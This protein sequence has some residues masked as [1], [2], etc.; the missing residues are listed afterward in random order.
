MAQQN[1]L[2]FNIAMHTKGMEQIA[3][4][5]NRVSALEAETKKLASANTTLGK[6]TEAVIQNGKR[7]NNALDAQSK[8]LRNAR[9]GSQMAMMQFQDFF[10]SVS[11]GASPI[12]AFN[13]QIGQLGYSLT[14]MQGGLGK[15]GRILSGP[16]GIALIVATSLLGAFKD[17]IFGTSNKTVDFA[18]TANT[19]FTSI[20]ENITNG[21]QPAIERLGPVISAVSQLWVVMKEIAVATVQGIVMLLNRLIGG[22]VGAINAVV[23]LVSN[24]MNIIKEIGA[25]VVNSFVKV[26]NYVIDGVEN[27]INNTKGVANS[28]L[29]FT[30][31]SFRFAETKF[32]RMTEVT[33]QWAG[34]TVKA[35][36]E[37]S[38]AFMKGFRTDYINLGDLSV[39]YKAKEDKKNG[40]ASKGLTDAQK[41]AKKLAEATARWNKAFPSEGVNNAAEVYKD[42]RIMMIKSAE[43]SNNRISDLDDEM[44]RNSIDRAAQMAKEIG[45]I[46]QAAGE[47]ISNFFQKPYEELQNS[48]RTIGQSVSDA[49]KG[50]LTGA[51]SWK[52]GMKSI[53]SAVI[54]QLWQLYVVQQIVGFV[55]KALGGLGAP[56]PAAASTAAANIITVNP[57][58]IA[59][60]FTPKA[61]GG[62]VGA[63]QPYLVGEKGPELFVP[64]GS[65]TIIPNK[66]M[67]MATSNSGG[68]NISVDARGSSDPAAV[69]A[70]V[71]AGILQAAPAIIAAAEARTV[72]GLRRPRLGGAIK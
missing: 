65:G 30:G 69:R 4:L 51:M 7:Y 67:G 33:N 25:A 40:G 34:S 23:I 24:G 38:N 22:V 39:S 46:S 8:A 21:L 55:T 31:A 52:D 1:N 13:Q 71:E 6:S 11:T 57:N 61:V 60:A 32:K 12:Q 68:I 17:Q 41:E 54:D 49:F 44:A 9:Q 27:F 35:V 14:M 59:S 16:V 3:M 28:F 66:N 18:K 63:Q 15:F 5:I 48:F 47:D 50:M 2:D 64:G 58:A 62:Y 19:A 29:E 36:S 43:F 70:Q 45:Y 56:N 53:I 72:A 26:V 10:T 20:S 37:A 42:Y